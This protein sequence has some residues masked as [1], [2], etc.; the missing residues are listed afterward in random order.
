VSKFNVH[1][2][3]SGNTEEAFNFY[4]STFG[5]EFRTVIRFKVMPMPGT[6]IPEKDLNEIMCI[7]LPVGKDDLLMASD[8]IR[9]FGHRL[10]KGN[11]YSI[12][13]FPDTKEE[14]D[15]IFNALSVG[16]TV[17]MPLANQQW[18][19]YYGGLTDRFGVR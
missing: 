1:L 17:E 5:G 3:F 7:A 12:S 6:S 4:R 10:V 16:G 13:I 2:N 19:D 8:V 14:A 9:S 15:R 11:N 18:G